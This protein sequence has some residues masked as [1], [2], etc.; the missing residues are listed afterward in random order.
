[1][2]RW[3][4]PSA[5]LEMSRSPMTK[6]ARLP[7]VHC[8]LTDNTRGPRAEATSLV[9]AGLVPL[10]TETS[11]QTWLARLLKAGDQSARRHAR[12]IHNP[13]SQRALRSSIRATQLRAA[14]SVSITRPR[15][16]NVD[17]RIPVQ[18][19]TGCGCI[20]CF[21]VN[22]VPVQVYMRFYFSA[23]EKDNCTCVSGCAHL[24]P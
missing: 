1:M 7:S 11:I 13:L 2:G 6:N 8:F 23:E 15:S 14:Q 22:R 19:A 5:K 4:R 17:A 12:K 24:E 3:P 10:V 18:A 9:G 21:L 16:E 20:L